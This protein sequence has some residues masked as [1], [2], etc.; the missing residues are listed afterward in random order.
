MKRFHLVIAC[1]FLF[2]MISQQAFALDGYQKRQGLYYG[3]GFGGGQASSDAEGAES[4]ITYNFRARVGGGID[5][6][7]TLDAEFSL[8]NGEDDIAGATVEYT[9]SLVGIGGSYFLN[10][11]LYVPADGGIASF[12]SESGDISNSETGLYVAGGLGYGCDADL[13]VGVR[14]TSNAKCTMPCQCLNF[15][16]TAN[17][18]KRSY[19][20]RFFF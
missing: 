4:H 15:G 7:L 14:A 20:P 12:E 19:L 17:G 10:K 1:A 2:S 13:A 9:T 6:N 16:V 8:Q 3:V 18:I 11:G 5:E